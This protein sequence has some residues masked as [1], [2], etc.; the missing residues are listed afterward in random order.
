MTASEPATG[1][2]SAPP[3]VV[4]SSAETQPHP[5]TSTQRVLWFIAA[6][7][8]GV[9]VIVMVGSVFAAR[10]LAERE[11]VNDA[12]TT[13]DLIA[14]AVVQPT[15]TDGVVEQEP[16][17]LA[18]LDRALTPW[19][20]DSAVVRAKLWRADGTVLWSDEPRLRGERFPLGDDEREVLR[21]PGTRAEVTDLKE[22]ENRFERG[23]GT[24]L[25]VYRPVFTPDG[26]PLLFEIYPSYDTV[27]GRSAQLW[28]GIAGITVTSLLLLVAL[29]S[30]VL[31]GLLRRLRQGQ[32]QREL[33]LH[34]ALDASAEER[35]RIA[36]TLHDGVV[37]ELA[38]TSYAVAGT[39][40]RARRTGQEGMADELGAASDTLR[41]S[42]GSLRS[43]LVEIYPRSLEHAGLVGALTDLVE[44]MRA[45]GLAVEL[46]LPEHEP[47]L[48]AASRRI[49]FRI[50]Q[51]CLHNVRKHARAERVHVRLGESSQGT[52]LEIADDGVGFD[53]EQTLA[54]PPEGHL[55]L[56][57]LADLASKYGARLAVR[58]SPGAGC[59]WTLQVPR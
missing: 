53:V 9:L 41:S 57:V 38:A 28:R 44:P 25:E 4:L 23:Q 45:R 33:L 47:E 49:V 13:A 7:A 32:H 27:E 35:R 52:V 31:S 12:A 2:T 26:T 50:A 58:S 14:R 46:E 6:S 55:G 54:H 29:L 16:E 17:A 11:A 1:T 15:L 22:P 3:E 20:T 8:V 5:E 51:E 42:I 59:R 36:S 34:Q 30:P 19:L 56:R 21:T 37:Q 10:T 40:A 39:E 48:P 18:S 43:L 24:L